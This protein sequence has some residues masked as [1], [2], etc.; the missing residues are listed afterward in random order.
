[1]LHTFRATGTT[2]YVSNGAT[3]EHPQQIAGHAS[4]EDDEALRTGRVDA[5]TVDEIERT[6]ILR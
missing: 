1:M 2:A 6:M 4:P 5:V 3:L